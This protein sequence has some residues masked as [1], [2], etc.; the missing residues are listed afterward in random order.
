MPPNGH[1]VHRYYFWV[2]A[3]D[4]EL[5]LDPGLTLWDMLSQIEPHLL[6]MNRL[7]G[8]YQRD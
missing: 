3:L 2:C 6:G 8:T 1:G 4:A 5:A 7:V